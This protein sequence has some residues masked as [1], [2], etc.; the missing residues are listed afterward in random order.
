MVVQ[1]THGSVIYKFKFQFQFQFQFQLQ[2]QLQD[3]ERLERDILPLMLSGT[4]G[5]NKVFLI[6]P[7]EKYSVIE[8]PPAIEAT[9]DHKSGD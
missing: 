7:Q 9:I 6:R 3:E 1:P 5:S 4:N 2:L 8:L